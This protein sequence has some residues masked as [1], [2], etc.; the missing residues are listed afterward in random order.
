MMPKVKAMGTKVNAKY[1]KFAIYA[2]SFGT[3]N[4]IIFKAGYIEALE[5][6]EV[7]RMLADPSQGQGQYSKFV[8][9]TSSIGS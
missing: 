4:G 8:I 1:S 3:S 5:I 9:F 7:W 6:Y 2:S